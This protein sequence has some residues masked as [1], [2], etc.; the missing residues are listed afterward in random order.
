MY[1]PVNGWKE[2]VRLDVF[3]AILTNTWKQFPDI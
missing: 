2:H 3:N 1:L